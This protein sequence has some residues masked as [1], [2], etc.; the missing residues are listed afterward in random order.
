MTCLPL[1]S[2]SIDYPLSCAPHLPL[3]PPSRPFIRR[4]SSGVT[5]YSERV[6]KVVWALPSG[7]PCCITV[8]EIAGRQQPLAAAQQPQPQTQQRAA[9]THR[10]S[11]PSHASVAAG[12]E[13]ALSFTDLLGRT[14]VYCMSGLPRNS[15][16]F[17]ELDSIHLFTLFVFA[18][19]VIIK[20]MLY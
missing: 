8:R 5:N 2:V 10:G 6:E 7:L 12:S 20:S 14:N 1:F 3:P 15:P 16:T 4:T 18:A 9:Q 13:G 17:E 11:N 19:V